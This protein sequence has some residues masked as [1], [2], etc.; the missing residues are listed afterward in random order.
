[1]KLSVQSKSL[2][3]APENAIGTLIADHKNMFVSVPLS[4]S[5]F[6]LPYELLADVSSAEVLSAAENALGRLLAMQNSLCGAAAS[7]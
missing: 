5:N 6:E 1:M 4:H 2:D 7:H 3:F